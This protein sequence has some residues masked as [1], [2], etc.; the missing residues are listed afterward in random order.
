MQTKGP[1]SAA[2]FVF[3]PHLLS[4]LPQFGTGFQFKSVGIGAAAVDYISHGVFLH[5]VTFFFYH[6]NF[7]ERRP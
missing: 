5:T 2:P 3:Q 1:L 7:T 6:S 4:I